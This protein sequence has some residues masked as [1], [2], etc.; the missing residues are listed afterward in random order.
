MTI[1]DYGSIS[2]KCFECGRNSF[3]LTRMEEG[4]V[5][6]EC[7]N[8]GHAH[9]LDSVLEKKSRTPFVYWFSAPKKAERCIECRS[10]L[11]IWDVSYDGRIAYSKCS[12]CGLSHTFKKKRFRDWNLVRI[13]RR[14][15]DQVPVSSIN[16]D[17]TQIKGIGVKRAEVF[18]AAGIRTISDLS[19]SPLQVLT[20]KTGIS[21]KFLIKWINQA[22]ELI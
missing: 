20:T 1:D 7:I 12:K 10:E 22:K 6:A 17:L 13:T 5:L 14:A 11:K 18:A 4:Q 9:F 16:V 8:C 19:N 21:E 15:D 2:T 3:R